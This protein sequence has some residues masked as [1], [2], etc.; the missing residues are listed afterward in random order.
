VPDFSA[1]AALAAGQLVQVL[2]QW[3]PMGAFSDT[4]YAMRPYSAHVPRAV[5]VFVD[6]VRAEFAPGFAPAGRG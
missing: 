4:I 3:R 1:Q 5:A 2:P 6:W